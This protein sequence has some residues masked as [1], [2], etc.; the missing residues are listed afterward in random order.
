MSSKICL[1]F[2]TFSRPAESER[3]PVKSKDVVEFRNLLSIISIQDS[4]RSCVRNKLKE[5]ETLAGV[6]VSVPYETGADELAGS[7]SSI[8]RR[9]AALE[10]L[11]V[12][13]CGCTVG[14]HDSLTFEKAVQEPFVDVRWQ[15]AGPQRPGGIDRGTRR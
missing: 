8:R 14:L 6:R 1:E 3:G 13:Q 12:R 9:S 11:K 15:R 7:C 10:S 2:L 4:L 5:C